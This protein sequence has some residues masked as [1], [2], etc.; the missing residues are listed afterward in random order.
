MRLWSRV[1]GS[2]FLPFLVR[3][4]P[5]RVGAMPACGEAM[6]DAK[7][8]TCPETQLRVRGPGVQGLGSGFRGLFFSGFR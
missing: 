4:P 1:S 7:V 8:K 5:G 6:G 2:A 3:I